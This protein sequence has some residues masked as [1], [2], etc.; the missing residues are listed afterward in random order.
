MAGLGHASTLRPARRDPSRGRLRPARR[1]ARLR[2]RR[3]REGG[4]GVH[5]QRPPDHRVQRARRLPSAPRHLLDPQRPGHRRLPVRRRQRHRQDRRQDHH[6][7]R[8][9]PAG[10]RGHLHRARQPDLGRRHRR[11][12]RGHLA[13]RV[14][15]QAARAEGP[16]GPVG[17]G[18]AVRREVLRRLP[19]RRVH[20]RAPEDRAPLHHRQARGRRASVRGAREALLLRHEPLQAGQGRRPVGHRRRVLARRPTARR[21]RVLRRSLVRLERRRHQAQGPVQRAARAGRVRL[22]LGRRDQDPARH[23][24][25]GQRGGGA[26]RA[27]RR[28]LQ[29]PFGQREFLGL[30]K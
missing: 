13:V 18:H 22:L 7:R 25:H 27:R 26:G 19:R 23:G 30:R 8:G 11:Q 5:H 9:H 29:V 14:G 17:Q 15:L 2:R 10:R 21:T 3:R 24:G 4:R 1:P 16:Q 28:R 20:G 6:D 12:R